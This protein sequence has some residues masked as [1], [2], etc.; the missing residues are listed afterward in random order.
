M[1]NR[2]KNGL[3]KIRAGSGLA[4]VRWGN[5]KS[6]LRFQ[7][8][9]RGAYLVSSPRV[10]GKIFLSYPKSLPGSEIFRGSN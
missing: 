5:R 3:W 10:R 4:G 1:I 8:R 7:G 9:G 6:W 2:K